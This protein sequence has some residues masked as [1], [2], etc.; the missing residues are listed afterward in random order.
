VIFADALI[1]RVRHV[2]IAGVIYG[3]TVRSVQLRRSS[4]PPSPLNPLSPDLIVAIMPSQEAGRRRW[5]N[6]CQEKTKI[7]KPFASFHLNIV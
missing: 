6:E 7:S 4:G 5:I 3:D 1:G 2:Q